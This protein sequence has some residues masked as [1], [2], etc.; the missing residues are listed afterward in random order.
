VADESA[1][2]RQPLP[3]IQDRTLNML[4]RFTKYF[5]EPHALMRDWRYAQTRAMREA[6]AEQL[7]A[8]APGWPVEQIIHDDQCEPEARP[9]DRAGQVRRLFY[10]RAALHAATRLETKMQARDLVMALGVFLV[11][12]V[13]GTALL[14]GLN[15][16]ADLAR[17]TKVQTYAAQYASFAAA[18]FMTALGG[19]LAWLS[20]GVSAKAYQTIVPAGQLLEAADVADVKEFSVRVLLRICPE[21]TP[22]DLRDTFRPLTVDAAGNPVDGQVICDDYSVS[23]LASAL[24]SSLVLFAGCAGALLLGGISLMFLPITYPLIVFGAGCLVIWAGA[25]LVLLPSLSARRSIGALEALRRSPTA[26]LVDQLSPAAFRQIEAAKVGQIAEAIADKTAFIELGRSTG[27]LAGR[28]DLLAP[29]CAGMPFGVTVESLSTHMLLLGS[30]GTGKTACGLRPVIAAWA[31]AKAGGLL[32][33]DGKG[34]LPAEVAD[35]PGFQVITPGKA[36]YAPMENLSPDQVADALFQAFAG[37]GDNKDP[38]WEKA[39]A[40]LIRSAAKMLALLVDMEEPGYRW[41]LGD[42]Y[43]MIFEASSVQV[44]KDAVVGNP[45]TQALAL[46]PGHLR[47]AYVDFTETFPAMPAETAN[48]IRQ[49]ASVWLG[50]L[51]NNGMLDGWAENDEGVQIEDALAGA[52]IG[53]L[54]PEFQFGQ[55]GAAISLLAKERFYGAIKRRGEGWK[56]G[57]D[58]QTRV[59]MVVDEVQAL[60]TESESAVLPIAR[61]LGLCMLAATQNLDGLQ[62]ALKNQPA[63]LEQILGQFRSVV[64]L[65]VNTDATCAFVSARMGAMPRA[66]FAEMPAPSADAAATVAGLQL[67][68]GSFGADTLLS[69]TAWTTQMQGMRGTGGLAG[70]AWAMVGQ[71]AEKSGMKKAM[72]MLPFAS[73]KDEKLGSAKL[74]IHPLVTPAEVRVLTAEKFTALAV[75]NRGGVERRDLI[76][77]SP[78]FEFPKSAEKAPVVDHAAVEVA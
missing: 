22:A 5:D 55:A 6:L 73:R 4:T 28:R 37:K 45:A 11:I 18:F 46:M 15:S 1:N 78:I 67:E 12:T 63:L 34:V 68:A 14:V 64:A 44:V 65:G 60:L 27:V 26:K 21:D 53:L 10:G 39:A 70:D 57:K 59:L 38:F 71:L 61:S 17:G 48:S 72:E 49:N 74:D 16:G 62:I 40:E 50:V 7:A 42:L 13:L 3:E 8:D 9:V 2:S 41:T 31:A 54:L 66:M 30:T 25:K 32:V 20:F 35:L 77:L 58:G 33:L 29:T 43:K 19:Y 47:R 23:W 51:V 76:K 69:R 56:S 36:K 24:C 52:R 75:V